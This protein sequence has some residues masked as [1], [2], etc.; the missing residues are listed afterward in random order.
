VT[1]R[2]VLM[3]ASAGAVGMVLPDAEAAPDKGW[4]AYDVATSREIRW[5]DL[6]GRLAAADAIFLGEQHDDS[7]THRAETALL[8]A[9][10]KKVGDRLTLAMEMFERDGQAALN[11]YLAGKADEAALGKAVRLWPNYA[12]DYRPM[13]EYAKAN[14]IPVLASNAPQRIA[15]KVGQEGLATVLASL[16]HEDKSLVAAYVNAPE[17]D[18]YAGRFSDVI[19]EG[20]SSGKGMDAA[21]VRRFY[22]AQCLRDDTMAETVARALND[23]RTVLHVNGSFHS[24]AGLGAAARVLW[25]RP[26]GTRLAIVKIVAYK[27]KPDP[28]PLQGEADYLVF[29]PD[30]PVTGKSSA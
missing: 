18:S 16:P 15:R 1:R 10:H 23:G 13:V 5:R 19:G 9:I 3:A 25:R 28:K 14:R 21:M 8:E 12:T 22:E 30:K 24:D 27:D 4:T 20:H 29:V 7:E 17:G 26:L 2:S 6:P 11:D